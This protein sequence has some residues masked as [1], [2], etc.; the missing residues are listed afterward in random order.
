MAPHIQRV[1]KYAE[2]SLVSSDAN[3][4]GLSRLGFDAKL[5]DIKISRTINII[6]DFFGFFKLVSFF[7]L[8]RFHCIHS[9]TPK[10]GLL[11]MLAAT[12]VGV[13]LRIHTFTGQ[14]W[15]TR[16]GLP[17]Y[18]L[19]FLDIAIGFMAT[20]LLVDSPSQRD[21]LIANH[22]VKGKKVT[23]LGMGSIV[24]VDA[25]RFAPNDVARSRIRAELGIGISEFVY[26]Y[27]G[28]L[29]QEKGIEDLFDAFNK[30]S[31]IYSDAHLLLVGPDEEGYD[32]RISK[33]TSDNQIKVHRVQFTDSPESFMAAADVICLPSYR[34]GFGSVLIEAAAVGLPAIAT[35]IYGITDAVI[36]GVTG[37]L[38]KPG[39]VSDLVLLMSQMRED[40]LSI[41]R[42]GVAAQKRARES[43]CQNQ[44]VDAFDEYY[45]EIGV[46]KA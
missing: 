42:M 33:L 20:N 23:V 37:L 7:R 19:K 3:A 12:L 17:R 26:I 27:V 6:S 30:V 38:Y 9:M 43:F 8:H 14:V 46:Y 45:R 25:E 24:G 40:E 44:L 32:T 29:K 34:E 36:N 28:R 41:E 5:N 4:F 39:Q 18:F 15:A 22:V 21:F 1:S 31:S 13:P 2:V 10:A 16:S 11:S 35:S